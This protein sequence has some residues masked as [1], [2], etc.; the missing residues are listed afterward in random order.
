ML[1]KSAYIVLETKCHHD[2]CGGILGGD[3][4]IA[5]HE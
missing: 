3:S 1:L 4:N 2:A 5:N